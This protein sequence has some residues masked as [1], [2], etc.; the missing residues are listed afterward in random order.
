MFSTTAVITLDVI[1]IH[2]I[3]GRQG[4]KEDVSSY[5]MAKKPV[6]TGD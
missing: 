5:R 6:G 1:K 4:E 2:V 3:K